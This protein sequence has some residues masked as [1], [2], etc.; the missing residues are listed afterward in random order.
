[1]PRRLSYKFFGPHHRRRQPA[2]YSNL[3]ISN[4]DLD[5]RRFRSRTRLSSSWFKNRFW[6][7]L[8]PGLSVA[9]LDICIIRTRK[10]RQKKI[11]EDK[12]TR[13]SSQVIFKSKPDDVIGTHIEGRYRCL[14]R[15][16]LMADLILQGRGKKKISCC[17]VLCIRITVGLPLSHFIFFSLYFCFRGPFSI[18]HFI[19]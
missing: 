3:F 18:Q 2:C 9:H 12:K 19:C 1:M 17:S 8:R 6:Q 14:P 16:R 5:P 15:R 10:T 11:T 4:L 13:E 7:S